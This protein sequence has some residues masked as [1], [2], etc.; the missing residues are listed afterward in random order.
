MSATVHSFS[1]SVPPTQLEL[2]VLLS[3][4]RY[5]SSTGMQ[6]VIVAVIYLGVGATLGLSVSKSILRPRALTEAVHT[7]NNSYEDDFKYIVLKISQSGRV[8]TTAVLTSVEGL[9]YA[10]LCISNLT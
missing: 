6:I 9:S 10:D 3:T 1:I 8:H 4:E 7:K 5:R 2:F